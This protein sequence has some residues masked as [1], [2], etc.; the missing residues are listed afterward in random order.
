MHCDDGGTKRIA[1]LTATR[2]DTNQFLLSQEA[3]QK[4]YPLWYFEVKATQDREKLSRIAAE[5]MFKVGSWRLSYAIL[6]SRTS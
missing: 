3:R 2:M 4:V 1:H 5:D 6:R